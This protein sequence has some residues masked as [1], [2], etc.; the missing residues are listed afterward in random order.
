MNSTK[1]ND[2]QKALN[3]VIKNFGKVNIIC[4]SKDSTYNH[5]PKKLEQN[6]DSTYL[7]LTSNNTIYQI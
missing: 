3:F 2:H 7:H 1:K 6:L 4:S 5:I